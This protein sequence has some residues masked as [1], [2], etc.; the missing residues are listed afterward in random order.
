[1]YRLSTWYNTFSILSIDVAV[2]A[3]VGALFFAQSSDI[4]VSFFSLL[5]LACTVWIIYTADHMLDVVHLK[6]HA[7]TERHLFHQKHFKQ[8][9]QWIFIIA[10]VDGV[11][12]FFLPEDTVLQGLALG[13]LVALYL[14]FQRKLKVTKEFSVA[15]LYVAGIVIPVSSI[16][17]ISKIDLVVVSA[18]FILA[19]I[20]LVFISIMEKESD[21]KDNHASIATTLNEKVL[22]WMLMALLVVVVVL[23]FLLFAVFDNQIPSL[24]LLAMAISLWLVIHFRNYFH[25]SYRMMADAVFLIP[26]FGL[27]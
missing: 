16:T 13:C 22:V 6:H 7:S 11:L 18:Y 25:K 20:N 1:M 8:L 17:E 5:S 14:L 26:V 24:I 12:L 15:L 4:S 3:V 19:F 21:L 10:G 9:T 2:G 27:L 23:C